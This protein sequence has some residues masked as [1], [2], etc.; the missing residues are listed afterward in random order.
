MTSSGPTHSNPATD[1]VTANQLADYQFITAPLQTDQNG[2]ALRCATGLGPPGISSNLALGGWYF[3]GMQIFVGS[4]C[5]GESNSV[6]QVRSANRRNFPGIINLYPCGPLSVDEE[7]IYSCMIMNSS[8]MVQTARVGLYLRGRSE[9]LNMYPITSLSIIF[10]PYTAAP[11]IDTPSSSTVIVFFGASLTLS[12][13]SQG[14]PPDTFT[15]MKD[16]TPVP[17]T[18]ALITITH[19]NTTAIFRSDYTISYV[20]TSDMGTYTCTVTNPI[21]SDSSTITLIGKQVYIYS[22]TLKMHRHLIALHSGFTVS[23]TE[24]LQQHV[25]KPF[26]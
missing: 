5:S 16:G 1:V 2:V 3:S 18:P 11:M 24:G 9:L 15:W 7:G 20:T 13:T 26:A 23:S 17:L 6:F 22:K 21:G 4:S 10:Y 19:T 25:L 8:M 14:S 12:C